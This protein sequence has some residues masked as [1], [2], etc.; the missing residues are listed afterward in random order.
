MH[1]TPDWVVDDP[2]EPEPPAVELRSTVV[3]YSDRPDRCT[4]SPPD[5][6]EPARLTTWLSADR[7]VFVDRDAM[8]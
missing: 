6:P 4:V 2:G 5:C 8:R 1:D 3:R 7:S